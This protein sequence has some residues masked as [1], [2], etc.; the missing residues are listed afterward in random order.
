[1]SRLPAAL[2]SGIQGRLDGGGGE[3]FL[4]ALAR[5]FSGALLFALPLLMTME[6]WELGSTMPPLRLALFLG[7]MF[8]VLGALAYYA[9]FEES[10][11]WREAVL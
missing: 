1:V 9:G 10:F 7:A 8:P 4:I 3:Q 6:R 5:A 11:G 2:R